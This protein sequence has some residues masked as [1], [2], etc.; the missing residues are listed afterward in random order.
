MSALLKPSSIRWIHLHERLNYLMPAKLSISTLGVFLLGFAT[1]APV[2]AQSTRAEVSIDWSAKEYTA[3]V[4]PTYQIVGSALMRP[5]SPI[6]DRVYQDLSDLQ[7]DLVRYQAW[8][9][10]PWLAVPELQPPADGKTS[11]NFSVMDPVVVDFLKSMNGHSKVLNLATIPE[12]MFKTEKPVRVPANPDQMADDYEQGTELRDPSFKEVADYFARLASWYIK[13]GF[14]DEYGKW[15]ESG[16]H[17]HIEYWEVLNEVDFEHQ[18]TPETYTK[19]YDAIVEAVRRV[20]PSIKFMGLALA[21]TSS[22]PWDKQ[23]PQ[24]FEYF[25]NHD[26]HKPGIPLDGISYHFYGVWTPDQTPE[27]YQYTVF[28]EADRFLTEVRY[29][30]AIRARLSPETKSF[31]NELGLISAEDNFF[32]GDPKHVAS[33]IPDCYWNIA[34][35]FYA[36]IYQNLSSLPGI[37][38]IGMSS[39]LG[40]PNFYYPSVS[41]MDWRTGQP[42]ARYW[43]LKL[44]VDNIRPGG[45]YVHSQVKLSY[46]SLPAYTNV[47]G[48][49]Y[50]SPEGKRK[51]LFVNKRSQRYD[52]VIKGA[53]GG[54]VEYVDQST[55]FQPP[56][57]KTLESEWIDPGVRGEN[58]SNASRPKDSFTLGAFGV[59]IVTLAQ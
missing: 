53:D 14:T 40:F 17:Y 6:H 15:H 44:L 31:I 7:A 5:T 10:Y 56:A 12:W 32:Q 21:G 16:H 50:V 39:G 19:V 47:E 41:M 26:N 46:T 49:G 35:A 8:F 22:V 59:V 1:I 11:W 28:E 4:V 33:P 58:S 13:G 51:I 48:Q 42:N 3:H 9:P 55:G 25:L 23:G 24:F 30:E 52:V 37:E 43:A 27:V 45:E 57:K 29:V 20:D 2:S 36:Y 38:A 18:M 34:A 54:T